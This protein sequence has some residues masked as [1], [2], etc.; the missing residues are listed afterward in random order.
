ML[1]SVGLVKCAQ[2]VAIEVCSPH[3]RAHCRRV[4]KIDCV[5]R[6]LEGRCWL[7][8]GGPAFVLGV[9][10]VEIPVA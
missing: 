4:Q 6:K 7:K 10:L 8:V 9:E 3:S 1:Q 2:W 5:R